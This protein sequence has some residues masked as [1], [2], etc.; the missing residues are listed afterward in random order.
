MAS[1]YGFRLFVLNGQVTLNCTFIHRNKCCLTLLL[2]AMTN[3]QSLFENT[4]KI[5]RICPCSE[6]KYK[7]GSFTICRNEKL[8]WSGTFTDQVIEQTPMRSGKSQGGLT[9][10]ITMQHERNGYC[11]PI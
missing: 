4:F 9:S 5:L 10:H 8:F 2:P 1:V 7:E 11:R 6:K 3:M